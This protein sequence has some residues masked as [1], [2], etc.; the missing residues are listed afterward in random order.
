[1]NKDGF[2]YKGVFVNGKYCIMQILENPW[3]YKS[4]ILYVNTNSI[5]MYNK[6]LF[7]RKFIIPS[8]GSGFHPYLNGVALL[9]DGK[10]YFSIKKWQDDFIEVASNYN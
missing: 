3:D 4:S 8:Y 5:G 1:M 9:F 10:K 2:E 6:N 7:S